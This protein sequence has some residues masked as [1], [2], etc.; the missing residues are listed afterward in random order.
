MKL[1]RELLDRLLDRLEDLEHRADLLE[2][3][4]L[5]DIRPSEMPD[6]LA[7]IAQADLIS[8]GEYRDYRVLHFL[9]RC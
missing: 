5:E 1:T 8:S 4:V 3:T 2:A 9:G 6:W 7:R